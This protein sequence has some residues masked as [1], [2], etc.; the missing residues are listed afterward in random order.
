MTAT[1]TVHLKLPP[2]HPRQRERAL[3]AGRV[4]VA[5]HPRASEVA[6][7]VA[8]GEEVGLERLGRQR[9]RHQTA[10]VMLDGAFVE[11]DE[12]SRQRLVVLGCP[13]AVTRAADDLAF[14]RSPTR[15]P[16]PRVD[17]D[18][19]IE[20]NSSRGRGHRLHT[21]RAGSGGSG[22]HAWRDAGAT[23]AS[24]TATQGDDTP[25]QHTNTKNKVQ[26]VTT[27]DLGTTRLVGNRYRPARPTRSA[28]QCQ[29]RTRNASLE[30]RQFRDCRRR[31]ST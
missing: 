16:D 12:L 3:D 10:R 29:P 21:G 8:R 5:F 14:D 6:P 24:G 20:G 13:H 17:G 9:Q 1:A 4:R 27:H 11:A 15:V 18:G 25:H 7:M 23:A 22:L 26:G 31:A 2:F 30:C 28:K 19:N